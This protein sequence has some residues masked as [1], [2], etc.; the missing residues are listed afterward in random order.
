MKTLASGSYNIAWFKLADFVA[1]GEK[2]R[3][4]SVYRL[5]MHSV[6]EAALTYK[7]EGD[8]L[9][10]FDDDAALDRYHIAAN[11]FKKSGKYQEAISLYQHALIF[12]KD[13]KIYEALLDIYILIKNKSG[14]LDTFSKIAQ[15]CLQKEKNDWLANLMHRALVQLDKT[16]QALLSERL[17]RAM[18][19]YDE[20]NNS[21]SSCIMQTLDLFQEAIAT[22]DISTSDLQKFLVDLKMLNLGEYKKAESYLKE[23]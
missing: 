5:L 12:K 23:I 1:R 8:I 21:I 9:L 3:A 2:E 16:M 17:V 6:S 10:A 15:L 13:E 22:E 4:L 19:M 7:L 18:L 11:L 14:I 20:K